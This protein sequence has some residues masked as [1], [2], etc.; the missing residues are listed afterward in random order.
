MTTV[1]R[2]LL[3]AV[4]SFSGGAIFLLPFLQEVYYIPLAEALELNNTEVGG[5][6]SIFGAFS[7]LSYFPGG[8]LADRWSPRKLMS[9]SLILTGAAGLYFATFPGYAVS[10]AIHALWG[11]LISLLFWGAM[12]RTTRNWA[13]AEQQGR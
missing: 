1:R 3:M 11:V 7:L 4:M 10:M 5:L 6:M 2:W 9:S 13:P 12:I 8:W